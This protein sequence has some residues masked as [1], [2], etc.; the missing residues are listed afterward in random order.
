MNRFNYYVIH[1]KDNNIRFNNIKNM[2]KKLSKEIN[3]FFG[4]KGTLVNSTNLNIYDPNIIIE[5]QFTYPGQLGCYLSHYLLIKSLINSNYDYTVIF[6]DDFNILIDNL[7][8]EINCLL[9]TIDIDFDFLFLGTQ[10]NY[11][12]NYYKDNLYFINKTH[13]IWGFHGYIINNKN[14]NKILQFLKKIKLEID[15]QIFN[16]I[17]K[18]NLIGLFVNTNYVSQNTKLVSTI[19]PKPFNNLLL[20]NK[21]VNNIVNTKNKNKIKNKI[22][23]KIENKLETKIEN[24]LETKIENKLETKIENKLETK[25]ENKLEN[26]NIIKQLHYFSNKALLLK[27]KL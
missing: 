8:Y 6:E 22:E 2:E 13:K 26:T 7:D 5:K 16:Q 11:Y 14:I 1:C 27:K 24:K 19:R 18:N 3:I 12:G 9:D 25:I 23:T 4:I 10:S 15:I 20:L 21:K 17:K